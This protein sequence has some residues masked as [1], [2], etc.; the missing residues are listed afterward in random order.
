[1]AFIVSVWRRRP[2][3]SFVAGFFSAADVPGPHQA[4]IAAWPELLIPATLLGFVHTLRSIAPLHALS[5]SFDV[6]FPL[7][8]SPATVR[9]FLHRGIRFLGRITGLG[10]QLLGFDH[11][12]QPYR[13]IRRPR[14]GFY[15][16]GRS[17]SPAVTAL[18]LSSSLRSSP[19]A[20]GLHLWSHPPVG[21]CAI[22]LPR[23]QR[24]RHEFTHAL[25]RIAGPT[26]SQ[27]G[28]VSIRI[29]KPV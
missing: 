16:Q 28:G 7:A 26:V 14:H 24:S 20:S 27:S 19:P 17:N 21:L 12:K 22:P 9:E 2:R 11:A 10:P 1:M 15:A 4:V 18:G 5:A 8:V 13:A 6:S 25:R 29:S 3:G 23:L